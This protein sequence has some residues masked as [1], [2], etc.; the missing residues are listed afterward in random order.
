MPNRLYQAHERQ[1]KILSDGSRPDSGRPF[2]GSRDLTRFVD[3]RQ[4]ELGKIIRCRH[5]TQSQP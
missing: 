2:A 1:R 4:T 5:S 3:I